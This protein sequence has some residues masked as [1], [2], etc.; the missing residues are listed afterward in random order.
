MIDK[1]ISFNT[2][3]IFAV[4]AIELSPRRIAVVVDNNNLVLGTI[5]D[6]DIRRHL[7]DKGT[8]ETPVLKVMNSNPIV[9]KIGSSD[10]Y[11]KD[12]MRHNNVIVLPLTDENGRFLRL[13]HLTDLEATGKTNISELNFSFA[14]IM[15]GGEGVRLRPLTKIIPKPMVE[16]GGVP[17]L[18][19]QI[20]RLT[21]AGIRKIYISIN[22]L[23]HVIEEYFGNGHDYDLEIFYLREKEKLGT[24]GA[25]SLLP[26]KPQGPIIVINGDILTSSDFESFFSFHNSNETKITI[27]AIEHSVDIPY[28]VIQPNG[29]FVKKIIEK[30][31]ER[32]L[33]NAGIYALSPE[34]LD[35]VPKNKFTDMTQLIDIC[36][37]KKIPVAVFPIHEYWSD[38][39]NIDDLENARAYFAKMEIV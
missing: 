32:F 39:G 2:T 20:E 10:G 26:E 11:I 15:A 25:L 36:L 19:R 21:K 5:T 17:L 4:R 12:L 28:G 24:A 13:I 22:Y 14:V 34:I 37:I 35:L 30:P 27:A 7:L 9:V 38:I 29:F 16:I 18:Q 1:P 8:L 33:C 3:L 6:G 31:S 23:S